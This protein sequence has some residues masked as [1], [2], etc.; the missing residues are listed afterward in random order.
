MT[1]TALPVGEV[2]LPEAVNLSTKRGK[3]YRAEK[4]RL[5]IELRQQGYT[6]K[7]IAKALGS[8]EATLSMY[9]WEHDPSLL[10]RPPA[11]KIY[12][13][14][15]E[16]EAVEH[17]AAERERR[18]ADHR[19]RVDAYRAMRQRGERLPSE[20]PQRPEV[21]RTPQ[22]EAE[23]AALMER[24]EFEMGRADMG[25]GERPQRSRSVGFAFSLDEKI[26]I[27]AKST[28]QGIEGGSWHDLTT[29]R[30]PAP[31]A[32]DEVLDAEYA[33]E[34]RHALGD[35]TEER[36]ERLDGETLDW[37]RDKLRDEGLV[38]IPVQRKERERLQ[39]PERKRGGYA[40]PPT[41]QRLSTKRR[42]RKEQVQLMSGK[43]IARKQRHKWKREQVVYDWKAA[44]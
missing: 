38:H 13:A 1:M 5:A 3:K 29:G 23:L 30:E 8:A 4:K 25:W 42:S 26:E 20:L 17:V 32:L 21:M 44:A 24:Q 41:F 7:A 18:E 43:R 9:I 39:R 31:S 14:E 37:L 11:Q 34:L 16:R 27:R 22:Q 36:L 10:H 19:A 2:Y 6:L 28:S 15:T 35:L 33:S 40:P 12:S